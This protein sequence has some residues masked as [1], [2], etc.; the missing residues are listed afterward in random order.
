MELEFDKEI[1]ALLR[2]ARSSQPG[3]TAAAAPKGTHLDAD[4]IAAFAE[5]AVPDAIRKTYTT[6]LADCDSCRKALSH[7]ALL[8]EPIALKAVAAAAGAP[9][10]RAAPPAPATAAKPVP[11]YRP[12]FRSPALAA[13]FGV[14]VLALG[15]GLVYLVTQRNSNTASTVAMDE[16]KPAASSVP[17]AGIDSG[18]NAN[19]ASTTSNTPVA[20][21]ASN[22]MNTA[23]RSTSNTASSSA[24][25]N[26]ANPPAVAGGSF[27]QSAPSGTTTAQPPAAAAPPPSD[28]PINGTGSRQ[29][30]DRDWCRQE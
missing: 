23:G 7:V 3:G 29:T 21:A 15:F 6:H 5:G 2:K 28:L 8:N 26:T 4:A 11:W 19:A 10:M 16:N 9:A 30:E 17:Y 20:N 22:T 24:A 27:G 13:A 25:S 18:S 12:L 14:L 1:D